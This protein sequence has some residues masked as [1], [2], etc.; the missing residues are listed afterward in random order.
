VT[1]LDGARP[2]PIGRLPARLVQF[3]RAHAS[4]ASLSPRL[5][6]LLLVAVGFG[7]LD[8]VR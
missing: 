1:S 4:I 2:L 6:T 5:C 7:P 8:R 3:Q